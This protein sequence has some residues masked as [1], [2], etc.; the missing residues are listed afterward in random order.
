MAPDADGW[1]M[2][3]NARGQSGLVPT[4]YITIQQGSSRRSA[5][6]PPAPRSA[7]AQTRQVFYAFDGSAAD[8]LSVQPG[9]QV[10]PTNRPAGEGWVE[11]QLGG[12]TGLIPGWALD[13]P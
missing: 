1:T 10:T 9:D 13:A 12:R 2:V 3:S 5:P 7:I 4:S 8:E 6:A 11:V